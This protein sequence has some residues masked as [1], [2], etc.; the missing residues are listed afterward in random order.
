LLQ[1][2]TFLV[3]SG[4]HA[5][6]AESISLPLLINQGLENNPEIQQILLEKQMNV[7]AKDQVGSL[8]DPWL[9]YMWYGENVET[10]T[11]PQEQRFGI[12]QKI[13]WPGKLSQ[14]KKV[15]QGLVDISE[16]QRLS[17][18]ADLVYQI[19][20]LWSEW[21]YLRN[22]QTITDSTQKI[23]QD[24]EKLLQ[25]Q[26]EVGAQAGS[27]YE[28]TSTMVRS[29][30]P[31]YSRLLKIQT[32]SDLLQ[33]STHSLSRRQNDR[34]NELVELTKIPS[35]S[36]QSLLE[37]DAGH[38]LLET[39][40]RQS[41]EL[42]FPEIPTD[43]PRLLA[44]VKSKEYWEQQ[45]QSGT[46]EYF[47]DFMLGFSYIQTGEAP[48]MPESGKDPWMLSLGMSLPLWVGAKSA[49]V[50]RSRFGEQK[51]ESGILQERL[52]LQRMQQQ[53]KDQIVESRR[54]R[55]LY[56]NSLMMRLE[57]SA[58]VLQKEYQAGRESFLM[59]LD[60]YEQQLE[61]E[62]EIA[63]A[64]KEEF[65]AKAGLLWLM[66]DSADTFNFPYLIS[67]VERSEP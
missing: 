25:V 66:G 52:R 27:L 44:A 10:R 35:E 6:A 5:S 41:G 57:S 32:E 36:L 43:N 2:L 51:A 40:A 13:P 19:R 21:L 8:P 16:K 20:L 58:A 60:V 15:A 34:L 46:R 30:S 18:S 28:G 33:E 61:F 67:Q 9:S 47:P 26:Y 31:L 12:Q 11:G 1:V 65:Q 50:E 59:L 29:G 56:Q 39:Y 14:Q 37:Q 3:F 54:R 23:Y 49:R 38:Q 55:K 4:I 63:K 42:P 64:F 7:A 62:R 53:M 24:L 45:T 17:K 22:L 48:G